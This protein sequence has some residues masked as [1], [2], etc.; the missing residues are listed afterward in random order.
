MSPLVSAMILVLTV[1]LALASGIAVGY[2]LIH[3]IIGSFGGP[4]RQQKPAP[5]LAPQTA[6]GD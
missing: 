6:S 1:I 4:A 3:L 5:A 2:G